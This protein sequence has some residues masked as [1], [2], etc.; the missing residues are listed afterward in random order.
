MS[1]ASRPAQVNATPTHP[2][3]IPTICLT[4]AT[5]CAR[6][7]DQSVS[8]SV[9][10]TLTTSKDS[11]A[12]LP[13]QPAIRKGARRER[14]LVAK[15]PAVE[16]RQQIAA[17]KSSLPRKPSKQAISHETELCN[18]M[19]N[20]TW[21]QG[22][23]YKAP[24]EWAPV[25]P[26]PPPRHVSNPHQF[27]TARQTS[28]PPPVSAP[29]HTQLRTA[30]P[31]PF[32]IMPVKT[33]DGSSKAGTMRS[34]K[35]S[36]GSVAS[37][38]G[39]I[40][41]NGT[42]RTQGTLRVHID[43]TVAAEPVLIKKKKSRLALDL[44]WALGD[45]TNPVQ[46]K[47]SESI[48]TSAPPAKEKGKLGLLKSKAS[49]IRLSLDSGS[50][51]EN[52]GKEKWKWSMALGRGKKEADLKDVIPAKLGRASTPVPA[53]ILNLPTFT[54]STGS[55]K[56]EYRSPSL[57]DFPPNVVVPPAA[58]KPMPTQNLRFASD[59]APYAHT[60][61]GELP[62]RT[63]LAPMAPH[64]RSRHTRSFSENVLSALTPRQAPAIDTAF[65]VNETGEVSGGR[66][67]PTFGKQAGSLALR[68]MRSVRSMAK[69]LTHPDEENTPVPA[70]KEKSKRKISKHWTKASI[71][72]P[73]ESTA[74]RRGSHESWLAGTP[75]SRLD[76]S[77]A[78]R[79]PPTPATISVGSLDL[80]LNQPIVSASIRERMSTAIN[81]V[82]GEAAGRPSGETFGTLRS[83][84]G[85]GSEDT[86]RTLSTGSGYSAE[87][88]GSSESNH[89][90]YGS[91]S[92]ASTRTGSDVLS[93]SVLSSN[94][95][96]LGVAS[97]IPSRKPTLVTL[98]ARPLDSRN[99]EARA[100]GS[101]ADLFDMAGL[102]ENKSPLSARSKWSTS[103]ISSDGHPSG[104]ESATLGSDVFAKSGTY[105]AL[106]IIPGSP[107]AALPTEEHHEEL[108]KPAVSSIHQTESTPLGSVGI[109][110]RTLALS[111]PAKHV[112]SENRTPQRTLDARPRPASDEIVTVTEME[113][114]KA[115]WDS[116]DGDVAICLVSAATNALGDLIN[117]LDLSVT[118]DCSPMKGLTPKRANTIGHM[119]FGA[120][121]PVPTT[122]K[123]SNWNSII[124]SKLS[125]GGSNTTEYSA[126][127]PLASAVAVSTFGRRVVRPQEPEATPTDHRYTQVTP[128]SSRAR[129]F[130]P[131]TPD[132][133][134]DGDTSFA[135]NDESPL[136]SR[137]KNSTGP[138]VFS[139]GSR[140]P[141]TPALNVRRTGKESTGTMLNAF[142]STASLS[143]GARFGITSDVGGN[144]PLAPLDLGIR[145]S[146]SA[147]QALD[148]GDDSDI[149][150]EL[151][152]ILSNHSDSAA[153]LSHKASFYDV[154][155]PGS[156]SALM[157]ALE[158]DTV[159]RAPIRSQTLPSLP[160]TRAPTLPLPGRPSHSRGQGSYGSTGEFKNEMEGM[161]TVSTQK[162]SATSIDESNYGS[163]AMHGR[164]NHNNA[165]EVH[166]ATMQLSEV[167]D[168]E[169]PSSP[170][171]SSSEGGRTD[172]TGRSDFDFTVELNR[173]NRGGARQSFVEELEN[174]FKSSADD[175][176]FF[177][178]GDMPPLPRS[179]VDNLVTSR[180][181]GGVGEYGGQ[182]DS[183]RNK[184]PDSTKVETDGYHMA[185]PDSMVYAV[186]NMDLSFVCSTAQ[187]QPQ[188]TA[189]QKVHAKPEHVRAASLSVC[190]DAS[191]AA[192]ARLDLS[193][194]PSNARP[195]TSSIES[196]GAGEVAKR[197]ARIARTRIARHRRE[198]ST[199]SGSSFGA[200][201]NSV[202]SDPFGYRSGGSGSVSGSMAPHVADDSGRNESIPSISSYGALLNSGVNN[203]FG[204]DPSMEREPSVYSKDNRPEMFRHSQLSMESDRSSFYFNSNRP[205]PTRRGHDS[206]ISYSS[207]SA[208]PPISL[209]NCTRQQNRPD[210]VYSASSLINTYGHE[211][212]FGKRL[213][214]ASHRYDPRR[215]SILSDFSGGRLGRP[216]IGDRM[217]ES[218][219]ALPPIAASPTNSS[220]GSQFGQ[221]EQHFVPR[222]SFESVTSRYDDEDSIFD[223][224]GSRPS[225]VS[226]ESVFGGE[227]P[228]RLFNTK[229]NPRFRPVSVYSTMSA[230][231]PL[232]RDDDT[233]VTMLGGD[234]ARVP[235][236]TLGFSFN[237]SPCV[238]AE[239]K[240]KR[241]FDIRKDQITSASQLEEEQ[242]EEQE[243]NRPPSIEII[244]SIPGTPALS[245]STSVR[246]SQAS[247]D[248]DR[249]RV[250]LES[251]SIPDLGV[252]SG[253]LRPHSKGYKRRS[254]H[255]HISVIESIAEEIISP[256]STPRESKRSS[257]F[258]SAAPSVAIYDPEMEMDSRRNSV[259]WDSQFGQVLRRYH[260]FRNEAFE[261]VAE[262]KM[263]WMDTDVSRFALSSFHAPYN[264]EAIEAFLEHS[265]KAYIPLPL[266]LRVSRPR[267][268]V[269]SRPAPYPKNSPIKLVKGTA[270]LTRGHKRSESSEQAFQCISPFEASATAP[271][272]LT[273]ATM[274]PLAPFSVNFQTQTAASIASVA[275][276]SV[277]PV[278]VSP[279]SAGPPPPR[280]RARN[281]L[282]W[283]RRQL[284]TDK[285]GNAG[286]DTKDNENRK[287]TL[288]FGNND[289]TKS[290]NIIPHTRVNVGK[291]NRE[292]EAQGTLVSPNPDG[293]LRITRA[294]PP[295]VRAARAALGPS[296]LRI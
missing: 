186:A 212:P 130:S 78:R 182:V 272:P 294:R 107:V 284:T 91:M 69:I 102:N 168:E 167:D 29:I 104:Q 238:R 150:D 178:T 216:D 195:L 38:Q 232:N 281:G 153:D 230:V 89:S 271:A 173:L 118:P 28:Q 269:I 45:R 144:K 290:T 99:A 108:S 235:R 14:V 77:P 250:M 194:H 16:A 5:P 128:R 76:Y 143:G 286:S 44:G 145:D 247:I 240:R 114:R 51:K 293:S 241:M 60:L 105:R 103:T 188:A 15:K 261:A 285:D 222:P 253:R 225:S 74:G 140:G 200:I 280:L 218:G 137:G 244:R 7:E 80:P 126:A 263:T 211:E 113:R 156:A 237:S 210:S 227:E 23:P 138:L 169:I 267:S 220:P 95:A 122:L 158:L 117:H 57:D 296:M 177:P 50:D 255:S 265:Q 30:V 84:R 115:M 179:L 193:A 160:P 127:T 214:R 70:A 73:L 275:Q 264:R 152:E 142:G 63:P 252:F 131:C 129:Q 134:A 110:G 223:Q 132:T 165:V 224:T 242:E 278:A 292:T 42:V 21:N 163:T 287:S 98:T 243:H 79:A 26:P 170:S 19:L 174:A 202:A 164:S 83:P 72:L 82:V 213:P 31:E 71:S 185:D 139:K 133:I 157:S 288:S 289:S 10:G 183:G 236:A 54:S 239:K 75:S 125:T 141:T 146:P 123:K 154:S 199:A 273:L 148:D 149:P 191:M 172:D 295:R 85:R 279:P 56:F 93:A 109:K 39:S 248:V 9:S 90:S 120:L 258:A 4:S 257:F 282:G 176:T 228:P 36:T 124:A 40:K 203:P 277:E 96:R 161:T 205:I 197:H 17:S 68:A 208:G 215:D 189:G 136:K 159:L 106:D 11:L 53:A 24:P 97:V 88:S 171:S 219:A 3:Q 206:I 67:T 61:R 155:I 41:S 86:H 187:D 100:R 62:P 6:P 94:A 2:A 162:A 111:L 119:D 47:A 49:S 268:R 204:Y 27:A 64:E 13:L 101:L 8:S 198:E 37:A 32:A 81:T 25:Q 254:G 147:P 135:I 1:Y 52:G 226:S 33:E 249:L 229:T 221:G 87:S 190:L 35:I 192:L 209:L 43:D 34:T 151:A 245:M 270:P 283:I 217:F 291:E 184:A 274:A 276:E 181:A 59:S 112:P 58:A 116:E 65:Q 251:A 18:K 201:Q 55:E 92:R 20:A 22:A 246:G 233:M 121:P 231:D 12:P 266:E 234:H 166:D 262:S 175:L 256:S 180:A 196:G 48:T 66:E 207:P 260:A 46:S 259:D